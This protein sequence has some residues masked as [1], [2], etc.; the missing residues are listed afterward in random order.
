[1]KTWSKAIPSEMSL[2]FAGTAVFNSFNDKLI[3]KRTQLSDSRRGKRGAQR[4]E[5]FAPSEAVC[6]WP[7]KPESLGFLPSVAVALFNCAKATASYVNKPLTASALPREG[8]SQS[9]NARFFFYLFFF[10]IDPTF[11]V[12]CII[13]AACSP[14][15][16]F[17]CWRMSCISLNTPIQH[18]YAFNNLTVLCQLIQLQQRSI[19]PQV[20]Q[21]RS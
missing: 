6:I 10:W 13:S 2:A 1:M 12:C 19:M 9:Q 8:G 18:I 4:C 21:G 5:L 16:W 15:P 20:L 3:S 11:K 14:V 17:I 7:G